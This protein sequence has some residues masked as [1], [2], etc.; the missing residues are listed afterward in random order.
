[1]TTET[2]VLLIM[3]IF[4]AGILP[5]WP[6]SRKWGYR[7]PGIL[8]ILLVVFIIWAISQG[9]PLFRSSD[10]DIETIVQDAGHD[11]KEAGRDVGDS[12]RRTVK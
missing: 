11:I 5:A 12:I 4:L 8:A 2:L 6:Y 10:R 9:R 1:M 7:P 3:V